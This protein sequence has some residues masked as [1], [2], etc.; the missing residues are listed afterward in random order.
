[1][2]TPHHDCLNDAPVRLHVSPPHRRRPD[3]TCTDSFPWSPLGTRNEGHKRVSHHSGSRTSAAS[4]SRGPEPTCPS[5]FGP[6][7]DI[8][9]S[10]TRL[11]RSTPTPGAGSSLIAHP[12]T[13]ERNFTYSPSRGPSAE[14][15]TRTSGGRVGFRH[16]ARSGR[17]KDDGIPWRVVPTGVR[18][19]MMAARCAKELLGGAAGPG[20]DIR[21]DY[22]RS[23]SPGKSVA[24]QDGSFVRSPYDAGRWA[25]PVASPSHWSDRSSSTFG[26]QPGLRW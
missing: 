7:P 22:L 14:I 24:E 4:S 3:S 10:P 20:R 8:R 25:H 19:P 6:T 1:M 11:R 15:S 13:V 17:M 21:S 9:E 12:L 23:E 2:R 5:G 26:I 18:V 16:G